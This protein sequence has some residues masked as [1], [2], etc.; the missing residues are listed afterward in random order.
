MSNT[1]CE[2]CTGDDPKMKEILESYE[3]NKDN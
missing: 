1:R 2:G 3:K